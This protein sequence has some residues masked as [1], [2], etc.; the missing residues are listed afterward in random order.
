MEEEYNNNLII[1]EEL[2]DSLYT[3]LRKLPQRIFS[4]KTTAMIGIELV[5]YKII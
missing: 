5:R 3:V 2:G 1:M 4:L